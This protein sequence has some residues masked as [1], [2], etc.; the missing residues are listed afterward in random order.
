MSGHGL[1]TRRSI[2][3]AAIAPGVSGC[4]WLGRS[5]HTAS[6]PAA[7]NYVIILAQGFPRGP[8]LS[9]AVLVRVVDFITRDIP[10]N[11][12]FAVLNGAT[13]ALVT[14]ADVPDRPGLR[15]PQNHRGPLQNRVDYFEEQRKSI[16]EFINN[17]GAESSANPPENTLIDIPV[18]LAAAGQY[19]LSTEAENK[20]IIV[21]DPV[22]NVVGLQHLSFVDG[23]YPSDGHLSGPPELTPFSV[24]GKQALLRQVSVYWGWIGDPPWAGRAHQVKVEEFWRKYVAGMQGAL[25][26]FG[27]GVDL[28]FDQSVSG[29]NGALVTP[30]VDVD[31]KLEMLGTQSVPMDVAIEIMLT[32]ATDDLRGRYSQTTPLTDEERSGKVRIA[33]LWEQLD[34]D[35]DLYVSIG[36]SDPSEE[37]YYARRTSDLGIFR[38]EFDPIDGVP[39]PSMGYEYVEL[40]QVAD[41]RTVQLSVNFFAGNAPDGVRGSIRVGIGEGNDLRVLVYPFAVPASDGNRGADRDDRW[42]SRHWFVRYLGDMLPG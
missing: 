40:Q 18:A 16:I 4:G 42:T 1:T 12:T 13:G 14:Q 19:Y 30:E 11:S 10:T 25:R 22:Y 8:S 35:M 23:Y 36:R 32:S 2:L 15:V 38:K 17:E 41:V 20:I 21:G 28:A 26:A 29:R 24:V 7:S 37:L 5:E 33:I 3:A 34:C 6:A 31:A 9:E 27:A 39:P